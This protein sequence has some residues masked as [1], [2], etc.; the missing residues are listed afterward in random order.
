MKRG[1]GSLKAGLDLT[2]VE[3]FILPLTPG[4]SESVSVLG[5]V[6]K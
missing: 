2:K 5:K 1:P 4:K 6:W 3:A